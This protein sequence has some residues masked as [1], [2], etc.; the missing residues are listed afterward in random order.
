ME[1]KRTRG[2]PKGTGHK[3][4]PYLDQVADLMLAEPGMKKTP[5]ITR[6]VTKNFPHVANPLSVERRLQRKWDKTQNERMAA[7]RERRAEARKAA[8]RSPYGDD[9][10]VL[11]ERITREAQRQQE[12][13]DTPGIRKVIEAAEAYQNATHP[14]L[15]KLRDIAQNQRMVF[16][17]PGIQRAIEAAKQYQQ[18]FDTPGVR[19]FQDR[20]QRFRK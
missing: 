18:I 9:L 2:R 7:A 16:N 13:L 8:C 1:Q 20:Y 17:A 12:A 15:Q 10:Q 4:G 14:D 11:I 5:A 3:D 19:A 6:I